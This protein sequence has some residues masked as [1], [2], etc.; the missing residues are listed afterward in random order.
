[1]TAS[2]VHVRSPGGTKQSSTP[3]CTAL[4]SRHTT[5]QSLGGLFEKCVNLLP[6]HTREVVQELIHAVAAFQVLH[7]CLH[8]H[9]GTD[10]DWRPRENLRIGMDDGAIGERDRSRL[11]HRV[12]PPER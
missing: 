8:R 12:P 1:M 6:A 5:Y 10:E 2:G 11:G 7:E 3:S 4:V 9:A